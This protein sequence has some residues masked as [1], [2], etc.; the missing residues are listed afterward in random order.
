MHR[1]REGSTGPHPT[2]TAEWRLPAPHSGQGCG[3]GTVL[4]KSERDEML[5]EG[6][7]LSDI[8]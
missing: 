4:T 5:L 7:A 3:E 2:A 6:S 1:G 8:A